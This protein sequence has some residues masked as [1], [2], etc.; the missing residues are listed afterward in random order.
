MKIFHS[1]LIVFL[2]VVMTGCMTQQPDE[3]KKSQ[4]QSSENTESVELNERDPLLIKFPDS[5]KQD[6]FIYLKGI[7]QKVI[8]FENTL[9]EY[10]YYI[11]DKNPKEIILFNSRQKSNGFDIYVNKKV[12][13]KGIYIT[14]T[15]SWKRISAEGLQIVEISIDEE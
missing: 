5:E 14:G 6:E 10:S 4:S 11:L 1:I 3:A 9:S 2:L 12:N 8:K 15:I 7:V 13:I